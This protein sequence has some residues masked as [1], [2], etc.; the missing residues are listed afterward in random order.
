MWKSVPSLEN[1]YCDMEYFGWIYLFFLSWKQI[2]PQHYLRNSSDAAV[3]MSWK[4]E[5]NRGLKI[6]HH[7]TLGGLISAGEHKLTDER[8]SGVLCSSLRWPFTCWLKEKLSQRLF[9]MLEGNV[10][11]EAPGGEQ[12]LNLRPLQMCGHTRATESGSFW[13]RRMW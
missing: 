9:E 8:W 5:K 6:V 11:L 1:K 10:R 2:E 4:T 3:R 7:Q 12:N 13:S